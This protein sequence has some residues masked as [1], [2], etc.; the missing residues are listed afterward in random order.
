MIE[1]ICGWFLHIC[2]FSNVYVIVCSCQCVSLCVNMACMCEIVSN[3]CIQG[4]VRVGR[5][6]LC[7]YICVYVHL[8]LIVY[9]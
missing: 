2:L 3:F 9:A 6:C 5:V 8:C 4:F 7:G 1:C